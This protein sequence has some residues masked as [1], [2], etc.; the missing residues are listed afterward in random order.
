MSCF[1][2][3]SSEYLLILNVLKIFY[4][5]IVNSTCILS[6]KSVSLGFHINDDREIDLIL[7][8]RYLVPEKRIN[9]GPYILWYFCSVLG[10]TCWFNLVFHWFK[11]GFQSVLYIFLCLPHLYFHDIIL[12][13]QIFIFKTLR[14]NGTKVLHF[15]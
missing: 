11:R 10:F 14:F 1:L 3:M 5:I 6:S 8:C 4:I 9:L 2:I 15:L 13:C 12:G 7:A